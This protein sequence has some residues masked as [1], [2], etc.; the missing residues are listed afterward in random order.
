MDEGNSYNVYVSSRRDQD[1]RLGL[2]V[3]RNSGLGSYLIA[4]LVSVKRVPVAYREGIEEHIAGASSKG[5]AKEVSYLGY[6]SYE[7]RS[8][9]R[10]NVGCYFPCEHLQDARRGLA[11]FIEAMATHHL[12]AARNIRRI[13]TSNVVSPERKEQLRRMELPVYKYTRMGEWL[14]GLGRGISRDMEKHGN[15]VAA[16]PVERREDLTAC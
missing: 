12:M 6:I 16:Q 4:D 13:S 10:A 7:L 5:Q 11:K 1:V 15:G 14:K 3:D 9:R 8:R 2:V